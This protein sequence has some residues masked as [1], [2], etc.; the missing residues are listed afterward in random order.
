M[1]NAYSTD[2][3][4]HAVQIYN[5]QCI[6]YQ[7]KLHAFTIS[8]NARDSTEQKQPTKGNRNSRKKSFFTTL[9]S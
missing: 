2:W 4:V 7:Q 8:I 9:F 3:P 1:Y 5:S 6:N